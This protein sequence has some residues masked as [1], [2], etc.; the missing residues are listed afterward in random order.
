MYNLENQTP[1]LGF[2]VHRIGINFLVIEFRW[3]P[4]GRNNQLSSLSSKGAP[5]VLNTNSQEIRFP[6]EISKLI[7]RSGSLSGETFATES[8]DVK[9]D[10]LIES[11]S[12]LSSVWLGS[13][14][15]PKGVIRRPWLRELLS[16]GC[17]Q[18]RREKTVY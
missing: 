13:F 8:I 6:E 7:L 18:A 5:G 11:G 12:C 1:F 17:S 15:K 4:M 3:S 10:A 9:D 14:W 16:Q 2:R